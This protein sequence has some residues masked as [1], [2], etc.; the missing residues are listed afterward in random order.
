MLKENK[1]T[2]GYRIACEADIPGM[3]VVRHAVKENRLSDPAL[4]PDSDVADYIMNRGRG[5]IST[6]DNSVVGFAIVSLS[7]NNVWALFIDP[8]FENK[9]IGSHL[10]REMIDWYFSQTSQ[11]IW[12]STAPGTRAEEFYR[13]KGWIGKGFTKSGEVLFEM[14]SDLWNQV[15]EQE[16]KTP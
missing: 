2:I 5:W 8:L 11:A 3:Q 14:E 4:V 12:L 9:G 1:E 13:C 10:H 7:D 16:R 6:C 15:K